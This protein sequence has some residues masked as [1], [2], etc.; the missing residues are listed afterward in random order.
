MQL[1]ELEYLVALADEGSFT[2]AAARCWVSQQALSRAVAALERRLGVLLVVRRAR[3][4]SLTPAGSRLVAAA[5]P[6]LR[7]ADALTG[8]ARGLAGDPTGGRLLRIGVL[9]DG[10]GARTPPVVAAFRAAWPGWRVAVR[11]VQPSDL[12]GVLLSGEVDAVLL[13]GPCT[14]PRVAVVPLFREGRAV[15]LSAADPRADA[16]ALSVQDLLT[17]PA[18]ARRAG[19]DPGWE[20]VFTLRAERGGEEPERVGEPAGS[21]EELLWA[22]SVDRLFLTVPQHVATSHPGAAYGVTY[23]PV[24]DAEPVTFAVAHRRTDRR[25]HVGAFV[26]LARSVAGS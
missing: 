26:Q 2:R 22:I 7:D 21:L 6:L 18:R 4:C 23:V 19:I 10:L 12:P 25:P 3:G 15:A 16:A 20:G 24:P 14:D 8:L 17:L 5:R 1:R 9:L 11:R 13:H